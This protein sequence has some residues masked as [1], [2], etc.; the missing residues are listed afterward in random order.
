MSQS[1]SIGHVMAEST[2]RQITRTVE[3][4][5]G[6][7]ISAVPD[8]VAIILNSPPANRYTISQEGTAVI[9]Q[10]ITIHPVIHPVTLTL[11]S[12]GDAV[13]KAWNAISAVANQAVTWIEVYGDCDCLRSQVFRG[14]SKV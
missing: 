13:R 11:E 14:R 1:L 12:H 6:G 4:T 2:S 3:T 5:S 10:G 7:L 9:D 8:R